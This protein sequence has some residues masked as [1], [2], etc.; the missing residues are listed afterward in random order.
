MNSLSPTGRC[1]LHALLAMLAV[2]TPPAIPMA[3]GAAT[4]TGDAAVAWHAPVLPEG[5]TIPSGK[6]LADFDAWIAAMAAINPDLGRRTD[7]PAFTRVEHEIR[8]ALRQPL[9]AREAWLHFARLSPTLR[10]G[11]S[12]VLPA[13]YRIRMQAHLDAGG[14]FFPLDVHLNRDGGLT[15]ATASPGIPDGTRIEAIN[16]L[17]AERIVADMMA[18]IEGDTPAFRRALASRRFAFMFWML[19]GDTGS[20]RVETAATSGKAPITLHGGTRFPAALTDA[21]YRHEVLEGGIGYIDAT[22]FGHE[23]ADA[24]ATAAR[25]AFTQFKRAGIRALIIDVRNNVGGDDPLWQEGLMEYITDKPYIHVSRYARAVT[26]ENREP[27][28]IVGMVRR[29]DYDRRISP[30]ADNPLRFDGPV[31]I[32]TGPLTYS[33]AIQFVVA[34]QDFAIARIVGEETA[35]LSCQTGRVTRIPLQN[36]GLNAFTPTMAF[37]RPSGLGCARGVMP[38]LRV[39]VDPAAGQ[40]TL[41]V[42]VARIRE[43]IATRAE[44]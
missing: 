19:Y 5:P 26:A 7:R 4:I 35:A 28:E 30:S 8:A 2:S 21:P 24:F 6:L 17:P 3:T 36:T 10:D 43:E 31:Y 16:G 9:T 41:D 34:A 40:R 27:G 12:G 22:G 11:H 1:G 20:Y 13:D 25:D 15:G 14:T 37:T 32:L 42:T 33:A 38:D 39:A 44:P 18:R 29:R 23:R